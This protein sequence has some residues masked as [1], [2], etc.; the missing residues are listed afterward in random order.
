MHYGHGSS[1]PSSPSSSFI[2]NPAVIATRATSMSM[3]G[4]GE[5]A[6]KTLNE[7]LHSWVTRKFGVGCA[8]LFPV[9]VTCYISWWFLS[10]FEGLFS[11]VWYTVFRFH[12]FGLGFLTS[13]A[14]ILFVGVFFSSWLGGVLLRV[15]E[16]IIHRLPVIQQIYSASKQISVA[17][18]PENESSAFQECVLI[19]HPRSN[20]FAWGFVTGRTI[21]SASPSQ[22]GGS[23]RLCSVYVPTNHV[24]LG[25]VFLVDEDKDVI[26]TNVSV[27]EG[28]EIVVSVGM[29]VPSQL[30]ARNLKILPS[31]AAGSST[32]AAD[33]A[34][35]S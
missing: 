6:K 8:I 15:G 24:Y 27:K 9:A 3:K 22:G 5:A 7:I 34:I 4:G 14:F 16:W 13:M 25:D 17:L 26:H 31:S 20:H 10:F 1:P 35:S 30:T 11:P 2:T 19:R 23:I 29:A 28:I 32:F 18:N 33:T 21:L 12:V